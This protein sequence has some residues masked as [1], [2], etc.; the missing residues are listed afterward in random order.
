MAAAATKATT[1][2]AML[3]IGLGDADVAVWSAGLENAD[4]AIGSRG[5]ENADVE[6]LSVSGAGSRELIKL[7]ELLLVV[8][9]SKKYALVLISPLKLV[10]PM[11]EIWIR[12][13]LGIC[14]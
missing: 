4:V 5:K 12:H 11:G 8:P 6:D 13:F 1:D 10:F 14:P 7:T 2:V 9:L 3:S